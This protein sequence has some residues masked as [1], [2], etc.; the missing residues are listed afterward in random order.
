MGTSEINLLR[1]SFERSKKDS[2]DLLAEKD[3][4]LGRISKE[5]DDKNSA[6][7]DVFTDKKMHE[8]LQ[9]LLIILKEEK[10][11]SMSNINN[12]ESLVSTS[13]DSTADSSGTNEIYQFLE[14]DTEKAKEPLEIS[15]SALNKFEYLTQENERLNEEAVKLTEE[16]VRLTKELHEVKNSNE[17]LTKRLSRYEDA[18]EEN[19]FEDFEE[20]MRN[21]EERNKKLLKAE[22]DLAE[23]DAQIKKLLKAQ[24][25][26]TEK[27][28]NIKTLIEKDETNTKEIKRLEKMIKKFEFKNEEL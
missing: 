17:D 28:N 4:R 7:R 1:E 2:E 14:D 9:N 23:K 20:M 11:K 27:N 13:V 22:E 12:Q 25:D 6:L 15:V 19:H 16:T 8:I 21:A 3:E 10:K 18:E 5:L 24:E 26:N